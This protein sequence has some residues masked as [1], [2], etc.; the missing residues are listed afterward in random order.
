VSKLTNAELAAKVEQLQSEL[1]AA[2]SAKTRTRFYSN[3]WP[4]DNRRTESDPA[5]LGTIR[6]VVDGTPYWLDMS[7]WDADPSRFKSNPPDFSVSMSETPAD[8]AAELETKRDAALAEKA[9]I[10]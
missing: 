6:V 4:N 1:E 9:N 2:K 10:R 3:L 7:Q 5:W 8:R